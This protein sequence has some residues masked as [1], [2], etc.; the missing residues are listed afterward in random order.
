MD[1]P[2]VK[3]I[4]PTSLSAWLLGKTE[5]ENREAHRI[6]HEV[7]AVRHNQAV[8]ADDYDSLQDAVDDAAARKLT[9]VH[10]NPASTYDLNQTLVLPA[11]VR[12][13]GDGAGFRSGAKLRATAA[14][15][16]MVELGDSSALVGCFLDGNNKAHVGA[17]LIGT[18]F[19]T[20]EGNTFANFPD[21]DGAAVRAGGALY[22]RLTGNFCSAVAGYGLDARKDYAPGIGY[23]GINVGASTMN[24]WGTLRLEGILT[25]V[26]DSFET[27]VNRAAPVVDV[28]GTV[29]SKLSL[30]EPYFEL[31]RGTH[32]I[33]A[34]KVNYSAKLNVSGGE[35]YCNDIYTDSTFLH[36]DRGTS[37]HIAGITVGRFHTLFAGRCAVNSC[38]TIMP[39]DV[40]DYTTSIDIEFLEAAKTVFIVNPGD[41]TGVA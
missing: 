33:T 1:F 38:I 22:T 17:R 3:H 5:E 11:N 35:A 28:G 32:S 15:E 26:S 2:T 18:R 30:I 31:K 12:L 9:T 19:N 10:L 14:L 41:K 29:Q 25:S 13:H 16:P 8:Y 39:L 27:V 4:L 36:F 20:L 6:W 34:I 23:Y 21:P 24:I 37:M 40:W 7:V